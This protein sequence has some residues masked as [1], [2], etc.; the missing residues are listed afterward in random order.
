MRRS[1]ATADIAARRG[2]A[3][4]VERSGDRTITVSG[5]TLV[6]DPAGALCW[7]DEGLLIVAD[8]HLEK[9]SAFAKR[10]V[11]LPPYD[12]ATTL[13]RL[14]R[15]IDR[16]APRLV[17][18]LGDS[19]HDDH[20]PSRMSGARS[21]RAARAP[22]RPRLA[23]DRR[24]SRSRSAG[25]HRRPFRR[26]AGARSAD[27]APRTLRS[28][29]RGRDR[30]TFTSGRAGGAARTCRQPALLRHRR[31]PSGHAGLRR[32]CGRSQC[33]GRSD[34]RPVRLA[35]LHRAHARHAAALCD[36]RDAVPAGL[37]LSRAET[38]RSRSSRSKAPS[39]RSPARK[40]G[41]GRA[42]PRPRIAQSRPSRSRT[43]NPC[44]QSGCRR[45]T[46]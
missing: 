27:L 10:G 2:C 6:A 23:L 29:D 1:A 33:A 8:L 4:P 28:G 45:R 25:G 46:A 38:R 42:R 37:K 14:A 9:G 20:G 31:P 7:P 35:R 17:I 43:R 41:R 13:S 32:L 34:F 18:A 30:R 5:V 19:F 16:H 11:L 26:G 24:Q 21:H 39:S 22:A 12:T 3:L 44:G 36:R 15:L 40:A